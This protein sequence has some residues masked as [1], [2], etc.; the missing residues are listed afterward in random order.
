ME[1]EIAATFICIAI[2]IS[3]TFP[4]MIFEKLGEKIRARI[5][6]K[7]SKPLFDC[8][9][10]MGSIWTILLYWGASNS[11]AFFESPILWVISYIPAPSH[12]L[13]ISMMIVIGMNAFASQLFRINDAIEALSE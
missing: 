8:L 11:F 5:G 4:E 1:F 12:G 2:H 13:L 10:C 3:F 6:E 9:A 7:L